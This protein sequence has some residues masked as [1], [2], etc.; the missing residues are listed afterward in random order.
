[1]V[2][3]RA[4]PLRIAVVTAASPGHHKHHKT[5]SDGDAGAPAHPAIMSQRGRGDERDVAAS[6]TVEE[7]ASRLIG[8]HLQPALQG[9]SPDDAPGIESAIA[10]LQRYSSGPPDRRDELGR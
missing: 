9:A 1:M 10:Y 7:A 8:I 2:S 3:L 6:F 5:H 4:N